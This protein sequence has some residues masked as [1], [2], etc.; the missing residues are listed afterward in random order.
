MI[1]DLIPTGQNSYSSVPMAKTRQSTIPTIQHNACNRNTLKTVQPSQNNFGSGEPP[2]QCS[3]K[4]RLDRS[5]CKNK[6]QHFDGS[7]DCV[8]VTVLNN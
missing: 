5:K 2:V 3:S 6:P 4:Q 7:T 1:A 8:S